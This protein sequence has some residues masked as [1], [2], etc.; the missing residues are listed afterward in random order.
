MTSTYITVHLGHMKRV[1]SLG[2]AHVDP[3]CLFL[4][5]HIDFFVFNL[6]HMPDRLNFICQLLYLIKPT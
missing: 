5:L 2:I 4:V 3:H 6:K 1:Q